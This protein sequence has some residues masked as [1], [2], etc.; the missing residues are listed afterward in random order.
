MIPLGYMAKRIIE[1]PD[2]LDVPSVRDVYAVSNCIS[3]DFADYINFWSHNGFWFFDK[4]SRITR[5]CTQH[6]ISLDDLTFVYY[7]AYSQQ[8]NTDDHTWHNFGPDPDLMTDV[9]SPMNPQL[10]GFDI[11]CYSMQNSPECS[12]LSCNHVTMDVRVNSHCLID[13]LD[14]AVECLETG[15]FDNAEPG[16][17]RII[18]V[19][20]LGSIADGEPSDEPDSPSRVF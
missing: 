12:P 9:L 17:M 18:A 13:T 1:R 10:L 7:E 4:P 8:F 11:V 3:P 15:I 19:H 14:Y 20:T 2:W 16:P 5:L 6:G